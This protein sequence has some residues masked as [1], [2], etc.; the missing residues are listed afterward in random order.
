[1]RKRPSGDTLVFSTNPRAEAASKTA[2]PTREPAAKGGVRIWLGRSGR[3]GK[4]ISIVRGLA[5]DSAALEALA[6]ELKRACG[7]GGS[8]KDGEILIQ[9]DHRERLAAALTAAGHRVKLAGG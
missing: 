3:N 2:P 1:M 8:A 6:S 5:M 4:A 7:T 9:G